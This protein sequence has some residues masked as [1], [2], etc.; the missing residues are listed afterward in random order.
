VDFES[1]MI[2]AFEAFCR[3]HQLPTGGDAEELVA[4]ARRTRDK[5]EWLEK[6]CTLWN[7]IL[8]PA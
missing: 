4:S 2:L 8:L 7:C 6:Y 3:A 1:F 5:R